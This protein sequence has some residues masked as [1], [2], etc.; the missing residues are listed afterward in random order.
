SVTTNTVTNMVDAYIQDSNVTVT[1]GNVTVTAGSSGTVSA[2][3]LSVAI[4]IG[5]GAGIAVTDAKSTIAGHTQ[6]YLGQNAHV[7]ASG[8]DV[9]VTSTSVANAS[10]DMKAGSGSIG[11]SVA[12]ASGTALITADTK[13][14][15]A[16]GA[17][18]T[19]NNLT[20]QTEDKLHE[21][22]RTATASMT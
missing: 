21:T 12:S 1:T 6:A 3:T 17:S 14:F 9:I 19:A 18:V 15:V 16:G 4:A 5:I 11:V 20:V 13:A 7:T 2:Q 22:K 10:A 8:G